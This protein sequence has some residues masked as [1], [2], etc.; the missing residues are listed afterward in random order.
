MRTRHTHI[1]GKG[2]VMRR[3]KL[4][5][6]V[7][8]AVAAASCADNST[9]SPVAPQSELRLGRS[10]GG[11]C[12]AAVARAIKA[13]QM[14]LFSGNNLKSAQDSWALVEAVC[15][16]TSADA[17]NSQLLAYVNLILGYYPAG[18]LQPRT[19]T[20]ATA[21]LGHI[22][23]AYKYVG[24][25]EPG[26]PDA[27]LDNTAALGVIVTSGSLT[28][29]DANA[30]L[31]LQ[32]QNSLGD[33]RAHLFAIYPD[34][35]ACD[36]DNLA[37]IGPCYEVASFP[38]VSPQWSP[39]IQVGVCTHSETE[40]AP[41]NIPALGHVTGGSTEIAGT[42]SGFPAC[43]VSAS[44]APGSWKD[45]GGVVTRLAWLGKR[46]FGPNVAYATH[47]G[48]TGTGTKT[49][50]WGGVDLRVFDA[51]VVV[52][53][54][55]VGSFPT[56]LPSGDGAW[57]AA[58]FATAPGSITVQSSLGQYNHPMI[59]MSQAGGACTKKCGG[60]L[61][62]GDLFSADGS[63][64]TVGK[65]RATFVALEDGPSVKEAPF[66]LR[67]DTNKELVRVSFVTRSSVNEIWVNYNSKTGAGTKIG[68][69]TTHV[70][71]TFTLTVDLGAGTASVEIGS[72]ST[73]VTGGFKDST[74]ANLA[75]ISFDARG[76]DSGITGWDDIRV[77]RLSD[78]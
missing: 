12:D 10:T 65:Y 13:E 69:W 29:G 21:F 19:G 76:I 43:G 14:N 16:T 38:E 25:A 34:P 64:A 67:D 32:D 23:T 28:T 52:P 61:L 72:S 35:T 62:Q 77:Q 66:S 48:I 75:R 58:S 57:D 5:G 9:Q 41:G 33:E 42:G 7:L 70:P 73:V 18:V 51:P 17:A 27:V 6:V 26:L 24:Y 31:R 54:N 78:K 2:L 36:T 49:S 4:A 11:A 50:P 44:V 30:E 60:L 22:N 68:T 45:F 71:E 15:S 1:Y 74:A 59:V 55:V 37:R 63:A 46:A 40:N 39:E 47:T 20:K 3:L 56:Q 8:V 53:P